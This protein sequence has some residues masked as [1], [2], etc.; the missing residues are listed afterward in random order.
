MVCDM[1]ERIK[2]NL[3]IMPEY[4]WG[5]AETQFREYIAYLQDEG[6]ETDVIVTHR[7]G[8][9]LDV[10]P[11]EHGGAI[12]FF[13][14]GSEKDIRHF[15]LE[16]TEKVCYN[17][18]ILY[19]PKD[20]CFYDVLSEFGV[21]VIYSER[22]DGAEVLNSSFY[23]D[24]LKK[25]HAV[26][27][28]S[29]YATEKINRELGISS[30]TINN[31]IEICQ[32]LEIKDNSKLRTILVPARIDRTKNQLS[33]LKFLKHSGRDVKVIFAGR[34]QNKAY[35]LKLK[36]YIEDNAIRDYVEFKGDVSNMKDL[37]ADADVVLN[38]SLCEGTPNIVL[39][40]YMLGRPVIA[41]DIE[42]ERGIIDERFL[43][44][45]GDEEGIGRCLDRLMGLKPD[46]YAELIK[47]NRKMVIEEYGI[48]KMVRAYETLSRS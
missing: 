39:E 28:N 32:P 36:H 6:I 46:D 5:G 30:I 31:G 15:L 40:A 21:K 22:N 13:E 48:P 37:Y 35:F 24:V 41:T 47:A 3:I 23:S 18:C 16:N 17:T 19:F 4:R 8:N 38:P 44:R 2:K 9:Y 1:L 10:I 43:Y 45:V 11:R 20:L 7:Y 33:V 25:C 14:F 12:R 42:A 29:R 34:V 27:S 26:T